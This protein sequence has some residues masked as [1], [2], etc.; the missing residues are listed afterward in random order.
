[1]VMD[2]AAVNDFQRAR[3]LLRIDPTCVRTT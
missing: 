1:M 2:W 3:A